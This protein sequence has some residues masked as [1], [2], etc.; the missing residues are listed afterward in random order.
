MIPIVPQSK[1]PRWVVLLLDLLF[2]TLALAFAYLIRFDIK[3][4]KELI[5]KEWEI[6]SKSLA[7]YILI[8]L[9]V[10]GYFKIH[11]GLVRHTSTD[12]LKR[13]FFACSISSILFFVFGMIRKNFIDGYYLFP[14][15]VLLVEYLASFMFLIGAR[16]TVKLLYL[17]SI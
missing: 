15:T 12:D 16:F 1:T 6:L 3:A 5:A 7:L 11:K 13:I 10:Y 2:S 14:Q 4:D 9:V 8:K 17:E